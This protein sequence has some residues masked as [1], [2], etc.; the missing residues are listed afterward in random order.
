[1]VYNVTEKELFFDEGKPIDIEKETEGNHVKHVIRRWN[2]KKVIRTSEVSEAG[3]PE[4]NDKVDC[5]K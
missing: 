5:S 2:E 1:M 4:E 3:L